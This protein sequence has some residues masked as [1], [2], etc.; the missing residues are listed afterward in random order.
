MLSEILRYKRP[1]ILCNV[2]EMKYP[3]YINKVRVKGD[4]W[5]DR[6]TSKQLM[7]EEIGCNCFRRRGSFWGMRRYLGL[8]K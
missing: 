6:S 2:L 4:A 8:D 5:I 1:Y 3:E 7:A